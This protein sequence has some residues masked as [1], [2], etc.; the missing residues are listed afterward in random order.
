MYKKQSN[1]KGLSG[2]TDIVLYPGINRGNGQIIEKYNQ[3]TFLFLSGNVSPV[4]CH[5][6]IM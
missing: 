4:Y 3:I 6:Q 5:L 1:I 2:E